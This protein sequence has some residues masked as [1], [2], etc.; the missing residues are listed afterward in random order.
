MDEKTIARF[1][2][3]VDR[4]GPDECWEW[5][6]AR[7]QR[8]YGV[9]TAD[10]VKFYAHRR[11]FAIN[12]GTLGDAAVVMHRCDNPPC[13]NPA[14]LVAGTQSDNMRDCVAKGR[15]VSWDKRGERHGM[16][17]LTEEQVLLIR[18]QRGITTQVA[19]AARF[20]V[21]QS[22]VSAIQLR[23]AWPHI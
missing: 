18:E 9:G 19:L 1:W 3:K 23:K 11:S 10:K 22:L 2:K 8:G 6:G 16:A 7:I 21:G 20:G 5:T 12:I 17:K 13:V 14:H 4:K 15:Y